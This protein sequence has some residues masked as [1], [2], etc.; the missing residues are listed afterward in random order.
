MSSASISLPVRP[1]AAISLK[2]EIYRCSEAGEYDPKTDNLTKWLLG[3]R[4]SYNWLGEV[5]ATMTAQFKSPVTLRP[6]HDFLMPRMVL[7]W[8]DQ[9]GTQHRVNE[10]LGVFSFLMP[11]QASDEFITV[12]TVNGVDHLFLLSQLTSDALQWFGN[13]TDYGT[14]ARTILQSAKSTIPL[15]LP[16]TP[17][18]LVKPET[19]RANEKILNR[20]V[21][22]YDKGEFWDLAATRLG[23]VTSFQRTVLGAS[24]PKRSLATT[25]VLGDISHQPDRDAFCNQVYV[26]SNSPEAD[27]TLLDGFKISFV[28]KKSPFST[29][30]AKIIS[31]P[32]SDARDTS[33]TTMQNR[34]IMMLESAAGLQER[35]VVPH[36]PDPRFDVRE[37]W[38]VHIEQRDSTVIADGPYRVEAMTFGGTPEDCAQVTTLSHLVDTAEFFEGSL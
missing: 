30:N 20:A 29:V 34:G 13:A 32:I 17:A 19:V 38:D 16:N 18:K 2:G 6:L 26:A 11:D 36:W 10:S 21:Q 15:D 37:A 33:F 5:K 4:V 24:Q 35:I 12:S 28:D 14:A 25:D 9:N 8:R 3:W 1:Y 7:T 31:K 23:S 22:L 27:I